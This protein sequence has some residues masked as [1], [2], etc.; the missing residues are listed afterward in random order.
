VLF[1]GYKPDTMPPDYGLYDRD[2]YLR[3]LD[4]VSRWLSDRATTDELDATYATADRVFAQYSGQQDLEQDGSFVF[5]VPARIDC[6]STAH[7][8]DF[9]P[10]LPIIRHLETGR[11]ALELT[12]G[13]PP[14]VID[15]YHYRPTTGRRG[16]VVFAPVFRDMAMIG[17]RALHLARQVVNDSAAFAVGKLG[18][19]VVG[20]GATLPSLT[21]FGRRVHVEA[22]V[23]TGH[24]GTCWL[25]GETVQRVLETSRGG[26]ES[27]GV[28]VA[29]GS[30][31][32]AAILH[33][34][35]RYPTSRILATDKR[36]DA[37]Q[38]EFASEP[39]VT[40]MAE[41]KAVLEGAPV[42]LAAITER[43]DLDIEAP[44][45]DLSHAVIVDDSQPP[46]FDRCQVES[47]GGSVVW[48]VGED[49]SLDRHATRL[50]QRL[51]LASARSLWG[52]EAEA[53]AIAY[54][55]EFGSAITAPVTVASARRMGGLLADSG[56][57]VGALESF[58]AATDLDT[59][60]SIGDGSG[61]VGTLSNSDRAFYD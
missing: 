55:G 48:V 32:K 3:K 45:L 29:A 21:R 51:G 60:P 47:R 31:G 17:P 33:L 52:C 58:G 18:V 43:I 11:E 23:T 1:G 19:S 53:A 35:D 54:T 46:T 15:C 25:I 4:V 16:Y 36:L 22:A 39:R 7:F 38:H 26:D 14:S 50:S 49:Q 56:I 10:F 12:A 44:G 61:R 30:I 2:G 41:T 40:V 13:L 34:L 6:S 59:Q 5:I 20:L 24:G 28:I 37:L 42:V 8:E 27:F 9:A 57:V